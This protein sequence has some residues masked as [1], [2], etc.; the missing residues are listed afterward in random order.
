MSCKHTQWSKT[1]C[2]GQMMCIECGFV[3]GR[4]RRIVH[5]AASRLLTTGS[6]M[7]YA[8]CVAWRKI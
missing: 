6:V 8:Q 2:P 4:F 7:G 3:W 1:S 5:C